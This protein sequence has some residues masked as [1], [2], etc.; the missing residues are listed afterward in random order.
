MRTRWKLMFLQ[1]LC[2]QMAVCQME[3]LLRGDL[4]VLGETDDRELP[5]RLKE[6]KQA[7]FVFLSLFI[8]VFFL[9]F[10][11]LSQSFLL[12]LQKSACSGLHSGTA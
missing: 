4:S 5:R 12:G 10:S 2:T 3:L 11:F 6:Y 1:R 9:F 8:L 7:V